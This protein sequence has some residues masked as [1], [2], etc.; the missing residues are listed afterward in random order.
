MGK[1]HFSMRDLDPEL[2]DLVDKTD[3]KILGRWARDC[4]NRI[5]HFYSEAF[6]NDDRPQQA[7]TTL[8]AWIRTGEFKMA[9]IRK[10]ALDAHAAAREVGTDSSARSAARSAGQAVATAHVSRHSL[11]AA[12]Y[13]LQAIYRKKGTQEAEKYVIEEREWQSSQLKELIKSQN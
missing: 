4:T 6:P 1:Y 2:V 7:L 9:V 8:E 5:L 10:A 13:A 11:A 3:K 12:N